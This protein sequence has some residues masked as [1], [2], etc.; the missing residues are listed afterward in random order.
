[1]GFM[2]LV[3]FIFEEPA[4]ICELGLLF[5]KKQQSFLFAS[6]NIVSMLTSLIA[7]NF[8]HLGM[9]LNGTVF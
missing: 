5:K 8:R 1:M 4:S 9:F 2:S 7:D 3:A 6:A